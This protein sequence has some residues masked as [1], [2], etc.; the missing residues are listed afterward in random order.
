MAIGSV[1]PGDVPMVLGAGGAGVAVASGILVAK[2]VEEAVR[3]Y[4]LQAA[5]SKS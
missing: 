5:S 1:R 3:S 4:R 2:D